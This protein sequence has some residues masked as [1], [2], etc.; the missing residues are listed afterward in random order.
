[1][2]TLLSVGLVAIAALLWSPESE[3]QCI[4]PCPPE[5]YYGAADY[6]Q[7]LCVIDAQGG[8]ETLNYWIC[9]KN[10]AWEYVSLYVYY[11]STTILDI[12]VVCTCVGLGPVW[13]WVW[14]NPNDQLSQDLFFYTGGAI[15][16]HDMWENA[17]DIVDNW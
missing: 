6:I 2:K 5:N 8:P 16:F 13:N 12:E 3:A 1:M 17:S 7:D 10:R 11:A 15:F 14:M 9:I 4:G